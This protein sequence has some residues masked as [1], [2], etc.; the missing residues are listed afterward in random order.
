V[1][2][3]KGDVEANTRTTFETRWLSVLPQ[4]C[5]VCCTEPNVE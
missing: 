2:L 5:F 1:R 3:D 4:I